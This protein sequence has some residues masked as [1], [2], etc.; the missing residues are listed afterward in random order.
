[1][2]I[3]EGRG[4]RRRGHRPDRHREVTYLAYLDAAAGAPGG[5]CAL[6]AFGR[7]RP[8]VGVG[9]DKDG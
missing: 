6:P 3:E 4:R 2:I 7:L 5:G 8:T 9:M 1:L